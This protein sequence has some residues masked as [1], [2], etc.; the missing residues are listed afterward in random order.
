MKEKSYETW[1]DNMTQYPWSILVGW[2][3]TETFELPPKMGVLC[4]DQMGGCIYGPW[5]ALTLHQRKD[6]YGDN[7]S[8]TVDYSMRENFEYPDDIGWTCSFEH[9]SGHPKSA[10]IY[11]HGFFKVSVPFGISIRVPVVPNQSEAVYKKMTWV[12]ERYEKA[13]VFGEPDKYRLELVAGH[14]DKVMWSK[15]ALSE[16]KKKYC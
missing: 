16:L 1:F 12:P 11:Q 13:P 2:N 7:L 5:R 4:I 15:K 3:F 6:A 10:A 8:F 9:W 14:W